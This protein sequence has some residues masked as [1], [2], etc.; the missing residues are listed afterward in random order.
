MIRFLRAPFAALFFVLLGGHAWAQGALLQAG[1]HSSGHVPMYLDSFGQT[2]VQDSGPAGGG[3]QGLGLSELLQV[4]RCPTFPCAGTG[5]GPLGTH[6]SLYDAPQQQSTPGGVLGG[7]YLA[8]DANAQDGP[9]IA[10]GAFGG[11]AALPCQFEI[12]GVLYPMVPTSGG[13]E[14]YG[15]P[16]L[17]SEPTNAVCGGN[18]ESIVAVAVTL[19]VLP[20]KGCLVTLSNGNTSNAALTVVSGLSNISR[21]PYGYDTPTQNNSLVLHTAPTNLFPLVN[22]RDTVTLQYDGTNWVP[23]SG[24]A[25]AMADAGQ[26]LYPAV[27]GLGNI[28]HQD[29]GAT[30]QFHMAMMGD[31]NWLLT[32]DIFTLQSFDD[33]IAFSVDITGTPTAGETQCI[34][35]TITPPAGGSPVAYPNCYTDVAGD[36]TSTIATGLNAAMYANT[37]MQNAYRSVDQ[38]T[39]GS[40]GGNSVGFDINYAYMN[41][42]AVTSSTHVTLTFNAGTYGSPGWLDANPGII[43]ARYPESAVGVARPTKAGD[44]WM[45]NDDVCGIQ[46][47]GNWIIETTD[48]NGSGDAVY[49]LGFGGANYETSGPVQSLWIGT[50]ISTNYGVAFSARPCVPDAGYGNMVACNVVEAGM[51]AGQ[52]ANTGTG[53]QLGQATDNTN[54]A[55]IGVDQAACKFPPCT[56]LTVANSSF[57]TNGGNTSVVNAPSSGGIVDLESHGAVIASLTAGLASFGVT[58]SGLPTHI[59]TAQ[60]TAPVLTSCGGGSPAITGTD[61]AGIVT[62]GTSATAC[63][64]TFNVAYASTPTCVVNWLATPLAVQAYAVSSANIVLEQTSASGNKATYVCFAQAGG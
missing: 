27:T 22:Y 19:P 31:C 57:L 25:G 62:M 12:D 9:L 51:A 3:M 47:C 18:Y 56:A 43:Y 61:E 26:A 54:F 5:T 28:I 40:T 1:S 63:T 48:V 55:A 53:I 10:C 41:N 16:T 38:R 33:S 49:A 44:L 14:G 11:A 29:G 60:P 50:G 39:G 34:T 24:T 6:F 45:A 42:P 7:H 17:I 15:T 59:A 2:T 8:F 32:A 30:C 4:S 21:F 37:A 46:G 58:G 52:G 36:T 23:I 64:I 20:P 13:G 35:I